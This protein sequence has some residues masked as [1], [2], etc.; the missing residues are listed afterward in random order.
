MGKKKKDQSDEK[1]QEDYWKILQNIS[2]WIRF[3]DQKSV[4]VITTYSVILTLIYTNSTDIYL[5][6]L[7]SKILTI[8]SIVSG[9]S[10][11]ISIY[12]SFQCLSPN[13]KNVNKTSIFFFGHIANHDSHLE[14]YKYSKSILQ[15]S[16]DLEENLA[17]QIYTNAKIATKKFKLVTLSIR[18][19]IL[20]IAI[21]LF[22][23][24]LYFS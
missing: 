9:L 1:I 6:I 11:A 15:N 20:S 3:S 13:L 5:A 22:S 7:N 19:Q 21:L 16:V 8:S 4:F 17:E 24:I 23:L 12:Y 18:A 14:Y 10:S 2:E